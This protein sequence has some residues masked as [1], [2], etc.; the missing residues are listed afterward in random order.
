MNANG[1]RMRSGSADAAEPDALPYGAYISGLTGYW[2]FKRACDVI[3]SCLALAVLSPLLLVVVTLIRADSNGSALFRQKRVGRGGK[4]FYIYKFRT[5][6]R[7]A[8]NF[9]KYFSK[10]EWEYYRKNRKLETDPRITPIGRFLRSTSLDELPQLLNVIKGD[11]SLI[12]PRPM[13]FEEVGQ[14]GLRFP[15]YCEMRPGISGLWQ[16]TQR[17]NTQMSARAEADEAY[18]RS[19]G[20]RT[21]LSIL[22][23]TVAVVLHKTGR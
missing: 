13:L 22:F 20:L 14:Y 5:M 1:M 8:H 16:V 12:G 3:C 9:E 4:P 19:A 11:M 6:V 2:A 23:K 7:D 18:F 10:S 17:Q 21:D 15:L